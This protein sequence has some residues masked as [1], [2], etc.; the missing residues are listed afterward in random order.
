MIW[1]K[2]SATAGKRGFPGLILIAISQKLAKLTKQSWQEKSVGVEQNRQLHGLRE[3][4]VEVRFGVGQL[5]LRF[6]NCIYD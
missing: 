3:R 1:R 2:L 6:H 4:G 5:V